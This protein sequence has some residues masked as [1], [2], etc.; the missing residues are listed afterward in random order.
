MRQYE[1]M[2]ILKP[3][4]DKEQAQALVSRFVE[5]IENNGGTVEKVSD[6]GKRRL[7]YEVKKYREGIYTLINFQSE[8][9]VATELERIFKISEDVIRYLIVRKDEE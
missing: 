5:V 2:F 7:A 3:E 8:A 6:W 1:T 9:A 4:F